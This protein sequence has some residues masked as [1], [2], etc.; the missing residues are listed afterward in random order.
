MSVLTFSC[1]FEIVVPGCRVRG[2]SNPPTLLC[3]SNGR[4][5][6]TSNSLAK[7]RLQGLPVSFISLL[8]A[9]ILDLVLL[10][11]Q[12]ASR[13]AGRL[14]PGHFSLTGTEP[15]V[16][17]GQ[18]AQVPQD[19]G[20]SKPYHKKRRYERGRPAANTQMGPCRTHSLS[21]GRLDVGN[22]SWGS[23]SEGY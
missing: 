9:A 16:L 12:C 18:L 13:P 3:S 23:Q 2:D 19:Q 5:R 15:W 14:E 20:K 21:A 22:F 11:S 7:L 6:C 17:S 4:A 10:L 1:I 8:L